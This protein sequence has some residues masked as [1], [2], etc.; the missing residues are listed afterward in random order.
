MSVKHDYCMQHK[1]L[2][3]GDLTAMCKDELISTVSEKCGFSKKET[4]TILNATLETIKETV[5]NGEKVQIVGFG[6]FS[7]CE[8][9][10][11]EAINPRTKERIK[12]PAKTVPVFKAGKTFKDS[13]NDA[14]KPKSKS[15]KH[16]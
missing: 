5:K 7:S 6:A 16:K 9:K 12:V 1:F 15:K 11:K 10:A 13:V 14:N 3:K 8:R 2:T 4:S